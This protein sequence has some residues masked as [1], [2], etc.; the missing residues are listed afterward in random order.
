MLLCSDVKFSGTH[1]MK[2]AEKIAGQ[3]IIDENY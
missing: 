3:G 1:V 2:I